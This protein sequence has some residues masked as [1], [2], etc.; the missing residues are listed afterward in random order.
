M[1]LNASARGG[2]RLKPLLSDCPH[3]PSS[4]L[5]SVGLSRV[6]V[7]V[8]SNIEKIS[9]SCNGSWVFPHTLSFDL[10]YGVCF[11]FISDRGTGH[12]TLCQLKAYDVVTSRLRGSWHGHHGVVTACS[13]RIF[14][15]DGTFEICSLRRFQRYN[16]MLLAA[17]VVLCTTSQHCCVTGSLYLVTPHLPS[18]PLTVVTDRGVCVVCGS[19]LSLASPGCV[20]LSTVSPV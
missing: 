15:C 7:Q 2:E 18:P 12:T 14:S 16:V 19:V 5:C 20:F 1:K 8:A 6:D 13:S 10:V 17:A 9:P 3:G 4:F 11:M